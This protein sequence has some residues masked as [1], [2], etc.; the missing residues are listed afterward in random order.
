MI[1][2]KYRKIIFII[3]IIIIAI[4]F[5]MWWLNFRPETIEG[6]AVGNG[7]LEATEV[8]IAT[9]FHGRVKEILIV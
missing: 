1:A 7:R 6:I 5:A 9:K 2:S 3:A 8:D 4:G